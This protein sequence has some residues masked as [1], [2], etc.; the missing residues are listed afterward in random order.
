MSQELQ[1]LVAK[2]DSEDGAKHVLQAVK[3]NKVKRGG[4]VI[5]SKNRDGKI[6]IKESDSWNWDA[7]TGAVIGG[8]AASLFLPGLGTIA[9][10][11][12]G[13]VVAKH[14]SSEFPKDKLEEMAETLEPE[15]SMILLLVDSDSVEAA[16]S[17]LSEA[18]AEYI[19]HTLSDDLVADLEATTKAGETQ[20]EAS[21]D[22]GDA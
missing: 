7:F 18:G 3:H 14:L 1:L 22:D 10:A 16:E 11:A 17:V 20:A 2:F 8:L 13:A 19:S 6:G 5:L 21:T 4:A 15:H 12:A 9:G